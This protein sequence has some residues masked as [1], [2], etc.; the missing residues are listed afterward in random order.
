MYVCVCVCVCKCACVCEGYIMP[1]KKS[2]GLNTFT[3]SYFSSPNASKALQT[4]K[5]TCKQK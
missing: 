5:Q 4:G 1:D 3:S 2:Q